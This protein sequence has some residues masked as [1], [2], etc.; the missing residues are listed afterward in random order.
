MVTDT[1]Q[2]Y[3]KSAKNIKVDETGK[4]VTYSDEYVVAKQGKD[5]VKSQGYVVYYDLTGENEI[6]RRLLSNDSYMAQ[7]SKYWV[8]AIDR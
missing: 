2:N 1:F 5:G 4:Y 6:E 8:G 3:T 7:Q